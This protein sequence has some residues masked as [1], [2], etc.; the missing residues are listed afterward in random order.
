M[1]AYMP[2][3]LLILCLYEVNNVGRS[4]DMPVAFAET[5][6]DERDAILNVNINGTLCVTQAILPGMI[7]RC[8]LRNTFEMAEH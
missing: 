7:S 1:L 6:S 5:T 4:H 8:V 3:S 2:S